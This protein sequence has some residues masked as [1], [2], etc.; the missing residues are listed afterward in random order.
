MLT[1]SILISRQKNLLAN[2]KLD[3]ALLSRFDLVFI[4][5]DCPNA[6]LD[7]QLSE[8]VLSAFTTRRAPKS[9]QF[10]TLH[11]DATMEDE[12][13]LYARLTKI[14]TMHQRLSHSQLRSVIAYAKAKVTPKMT[15]EAAA[16][17]QAFYLELR[18]THYSQT[19]DILPITTR[20]LESLIRLSEARAKMELRPIVLES[21][22]KDVVELMRYCMYD[23]LKPVG[24]DGS[25]GLAGKRNKGNGR[26]ALLKRFIS[27][28]IQISCNTGETMFSEHQL[29]NLHGTL[30]MGATYPFLDLIEALNQHGYI[31]KRGQGQY[32]LCVT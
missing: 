31:L 1:F 19:D 21:D 7:K 18:K 2:L 28:L 10:C 25:N 16:I 4:L 29:R 27:E 26:S 22:A 17:L 3:P 30:Q 6:E 11:E 14:E 13:S 15:R 5:L 23:Y 32:R 20:H 12:G 24:S 9:A 8:Q